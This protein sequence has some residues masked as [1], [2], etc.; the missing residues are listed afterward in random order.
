MEEQKDMEIDLGVLLWNFWKILRRTWW[1]I[2]I[3]ALLTGAA[4]YVKASRFYTPMYQ[5][6]ASFTVMTGGE[7]GQSY[8]FYYDTTTAG[9]L[10]KTFPYI[11]GSSLL[12]D[13]MKEDMGT[14]VINGSISAQAVSDSNLITMTAT[15]SS[16]EDAKAILES[17]IRVY[18]DVARFVIGSTQFNMIDVPTLPTEP[19]NRPSYTRQVEKWA[20]MG[21]ASAVVLIAL[22]ALLRKTV[23]KPEELKAIMSLQCI[24]NIP[25]VHF[26]AR[27]RSG[28]RTV[29][30][31]TEGIPQGF[32]ESFVSLQVRLEREMENRNAKILMVTSTAAGEGKSVTAVNL[33]LTAASHGKKVLLI[34]GDLR[35]Q[36]T[37]KRITQEQGSGLEAVV[38]QGV[39][40]KD[41]LFRDTSSGIWLLAGDKPAQH[42]PKIL[43]SSAMR[44]VLDA[45]REEM[46][47]IIV[48][49][50]PCGMFEDA[51][52]WAEYA[53]CIL[54]VVRHDFVQRRRIQDGI[55]VLED[56]Q[57][58]ILGF[59]FNQV[60]VH[61]GGYGNYGY[62]RYGYGYYGYGKYGYG[63]YGYANYG[64]KAGDSEKD[65]K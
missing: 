65:P 22:A 45:C 24:G 10:A 35:R 32:K 60:P 37:R 43:N 12:T 55:S 30:I 52:V 41:A 64:D 47:L 36:D 16:P 33:A 54:Y 42:V 27:S 57:A 29:S 3:L 61:R 56:G 25:E 59:A 39:P 58:A 38:T 5:S 1:L 9:Q 13:A 8:N 50:P 17:A 53:E 4:G 19:Y 49:A 23:Q 20:F 34:D 48:D 26:K 40:L 14:D 63:K 44:E 21:A 62:G 7:D 46:D 11:L 15:S 6:S 18:P 28:E 31:R 51:G 2:P